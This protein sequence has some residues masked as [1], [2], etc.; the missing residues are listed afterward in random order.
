[1]R[2]TKAKQIRRQVYGDT[3]IKARRRYAETSND[4][5]STTRVCTGLRRT[6]QKAKRMKING[7]E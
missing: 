7:I 1:M 3:S 4:N 6:Y 2:G 5:G